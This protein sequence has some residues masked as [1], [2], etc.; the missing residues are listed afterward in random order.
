MDFKLKAG[1]NI[2]LSKERKEE[3]MKNAE[4][5]YGSFLKH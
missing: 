1:Q 5:A 3:M 2:V 4:E